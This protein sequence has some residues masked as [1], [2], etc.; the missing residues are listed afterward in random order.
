MAE[1]AADAVN[2]L[3]PNAIH[4]RAV[5]LAIPVTNS[6]PASTVFRRTLLG[7][8]GQIVVSA[9]AIALLGGHHVLAAGK[10]TDAESDVSI[11]NVAVGLE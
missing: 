9:G 11:L 7:T 1:S 10:A 2:E 4:G 3:D 5:S 6:I 8:T